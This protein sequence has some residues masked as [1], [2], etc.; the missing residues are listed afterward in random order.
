MPTLKR[1]SG[2]KFKELKF[3]KGAFKYRYAISNLGRLVSYE[4]D[5]NKGSLLKC[6]IQKG[7]KIWRCK[8]AGKTK[9][10]LI[11]KLVAENFLGKPKMKDALVIHLD[12]KKDNNNAKNLKF[13]TLLDQRR[14]ANKS[15]A[16]KKAFANLQALNRK[17]AGGNKLKVAQVK[18]LKKTLKD[19]KRKISHK[20]LAKIY[21]ISEMQIYRIKRGDLWKSVK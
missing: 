2:E 4:K 20:A 6:G 11:H 10:F 8:P 5:V 9:A 1:L 15:A 18:A 13:V 12:H 21:K 19:P 7:F 14:H 17:N 3:K 16:S